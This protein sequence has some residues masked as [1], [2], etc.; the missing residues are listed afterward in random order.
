MAP[1]KSPSCP[2]LLKRRLE[3]TA[4]NIYSIDDVKEWKNS[5]SMKRVLDAW[6]KFKTKIS[7]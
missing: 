4:I 1:R 7:K 6:D 2:R 3:N 5:E